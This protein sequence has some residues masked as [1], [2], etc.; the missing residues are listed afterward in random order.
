MQCA[1]HVPTYSLLC[2]YYFAR[3]LLD[4]IV[5][6]PLLTSYCLFPFSSS[7]SSVFFF[8]ATAASSVVSVC[9]LLFFLSLFFF[10]YSQKSLKQRTSKEIY[11]FFSCLC[12]I[13]VYLCAHTFAGFQFIFPSVAT[14]FFS[15]SILSRIGTHT[16]QLFLLF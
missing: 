7:Y 12:S 14:F 16:D 3:V 6:H 2:A 10:T 1:V 9:V 15:A 8:A 13:G 11:T 4:I 5:F